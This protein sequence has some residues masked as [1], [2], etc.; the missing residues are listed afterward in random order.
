MVGGDGSALGAIQALELNDMRIDRFLSAAAGALALLVLALVGCGGT[1]REARQLGSL[2]ILEATKPLDR[3]LVKRNEIEP[4]SDAS[5]VRTLLQF[6]SILQQAKYE[7]ATSYFDPP[8]L[9]SAGAARLA[10]A[11]RKL[12]ALWDS[13]K[14]TIAVATTAHGVARVYF[15][16]R[17]LQGK[18]G[19]A[20]IT[21]RKAGTRWKISFL[22]LVPT[23][24]AG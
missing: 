23:V 6:W 11:L 13:T 10:V 15:T 3:N 21:F 20:E 4:A 19:A 2:S 7:S 5:G 22:S 1:A 8:L 18:A 9:R 17:D 12:A 14:P 24:P 16:V